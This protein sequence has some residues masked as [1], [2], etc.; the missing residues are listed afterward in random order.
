LKGR[1]R[2]ELGLFFLGRR[3]KTWSIG[4]ERGSLFYKLGK[5]RNCAGSAEKKKKEGR[6]SSIIPFLSRSGKGRRKR[7]WPEKGRGSRLLPCLFPLPAHP[8]KGE[9]KKRRKVLRDDTRKGGGRGE[10]KGISIIFRKKRLETGV[11]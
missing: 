11:I 4:G 1:K 3:K 8:E 10:G 5:E 9:R 6:D 2:R 7:G